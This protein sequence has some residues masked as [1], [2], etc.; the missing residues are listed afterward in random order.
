MGARPSEFTDS[1]ENLLFAKRANGRPELALIAEVLI[2]AVEDLRRGPGRTAGSRNDYDNLRAWIEEKSGEA[3]AFEWCCEH[4]DFDPRAWR[5]ALLAIQPAKMKSY[6]KDMRNVRTLANR[7]VVLTQP[8][9][10]RRTRAA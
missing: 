2:R 10:K 4:L 3:Y 7:K 1:E 5:R 6:T 8:Q 9:K